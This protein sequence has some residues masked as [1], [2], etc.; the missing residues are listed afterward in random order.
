V[1]DRQA[2]AGIG[3]GAVA[4]QP[5]LLQRQMRGQWAHRQAVA[6]RLDRLEGSDRPGRQLL[7]Q[8]LG[9]IGQR[10]IRMHRIHRARGQAGGGIHRLV[11][12][13]PLLGLGRP[14]AP[15]E[16]VRRA[17]VGRQPDAHI[18]GAQLHRLGG[19]DEVRAQRQADARPRDRTAHRAH[20]RHRCRRQ[21][22]DG[23]MKG[24]DQLRQQRTHAL[25]GCS[26]GRDVATRTEHP[27]SGRQQ[28]DP[29][30]GVQHGVNGLDQRRGADQ[31]DH[32]RLRG[33]G[34]HDAAYAVIV[35]VAAHGVVVAHLKRLLHP[36]GV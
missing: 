10:R 13:Q 18:A 25:A 4:Q 34:Q 2:L 29:W 1:R 8:G 11:E 30:L 36:Q 17:H 20:H 24:R 15:R 28:H 33:T 22:F 6:Q 7:H 31:V 9:G 19:E 32:I 5:V 23:R 3:T 16:E 21:A 35:H 26:V 12:H 14:D 27:P